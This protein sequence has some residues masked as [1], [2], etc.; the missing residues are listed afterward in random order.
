PQVRKK[1][2]GFENVK[3]Q[4]LD[5]SGGG[6]AFA[7]KM[8]Q[9]NNE[10]IDPSLL[11]SFLPE[12]PSFLFEPDAIISLNILNQLDILIIDFLKTK[13][14][15]I[16]ESDLSAFRRI[17]QEFHIKWITQKPGCLITDVLEENRSPQGK[18]TNID[19]LHT[20]LPKSSRSEQ[21]I[22]DFDLS[23]FYHRDRITKMHVQ[24][25]EW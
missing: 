3:I 5:I 25:L 20:D 11:K 12:T 22:W 15:N 4:E 24:A 19:L 13:I 6:I 7:W 18:L 16:S 2:E 17:I 23:G 21:W 8:V 14:Q 10:Y 9:I 1:L